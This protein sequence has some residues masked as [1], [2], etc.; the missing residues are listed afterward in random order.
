MITQNHRG[1]DND[2]ISDGAPPH[3]TTRAYFL[4]TL[5]QMIAHC[6]E[7]GNYAKISKIIDNLYSLGL[8]PITQ[9]DLDQFEWEFIR[10]TQEGSYYVVDAKRRDWIV[11]NALP[12]TVLR[13]HPFGMTDLTIDDEAACGAFHTRW[14]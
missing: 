1:L 14:G 12:H 11:Q 3:R 8:M 9:A 13:S 2:M 7:D 4:E 10:P 6:A 5:L